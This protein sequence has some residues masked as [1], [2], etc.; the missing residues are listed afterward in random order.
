MTGFEDIRIGDLR[1]RVAIEQPLRVG[2]GGGGAV[3]S[4]IEVAQVWARIRPLSGTERTEADA[5]A[6]VVTHEAILRY[7]SDL[8]PELRMRI[9]SRLFDIRTVFDI[10]ERRRFLRCLIEERDL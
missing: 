3:E 5:I 1:E 8:G 2:D 6:G 7:R 4:W 9:G 10:E